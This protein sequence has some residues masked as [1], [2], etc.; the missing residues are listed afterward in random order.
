MFCSAAR[1]YVRMGHG[2]AARRADRVPALLEKQ[3]GECYWCGV[4]MNDGAPDNRATIDHVVPLCRGGR[5]VE[6]NR[7]LAC[8]LCNNIKGGKS[9]MHFEAM[10]RA[11]RAGLAEDLRL[12]HAYSPEAMLRYG[13]LTPEEYRLATAAWMG[14]STAERT[15][16]NGSDAGSNPAPSTTPAPRTS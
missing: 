15:A 4:T 8:H 11:A 16:H 12:L 9:P 10:I 6:G 2:R 1:D 7:V 14:S 5:D 13:V 3:S